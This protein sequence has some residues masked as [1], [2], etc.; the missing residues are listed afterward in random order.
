M[1]DYRSKQN[2][3]SDKWKDIRIWIA[4]VKDLNM[5][6]YGTTNEAYKGF[7]NLVKIK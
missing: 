2:L 3:F 4:R 6:N 1:L 5:D 7:G